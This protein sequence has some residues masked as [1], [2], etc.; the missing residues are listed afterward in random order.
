MEAVATL[1]ITCS[2]FQLPRHGF[3]A[4]SLC[5]QIYARDSA[6]RFLDLQE[7]STQLASAMEHLQNSVDKSP[8]LV[9]KE[10]KE[11]WNITL[12]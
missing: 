10:H 2:V 4:A 5:K 12:L 6:D 3:K 1:S 8:R 11:L 9:R 7:Y